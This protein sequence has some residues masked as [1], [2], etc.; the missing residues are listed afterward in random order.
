VAVGIDVSLYFQ[1]PIFDVPSG[2]ALAKSLEA[3]SSKRLPPVCLE[4]LSEMN[5]SAEALS[6]VWRANAVAAVDK[7]P[8]DAALDAI[9]GGI[10]ARLSAY[11]ALPAANYPVAAKAL[12][13]KE[14]LFPDGL[15]FLKLAYVEEWAESDK[16]MRQIEDL[17]LEGALEKFVGRDFVE[18]LGKAHEVYGAVLG[19]T[20][21][22]RP[23]A[24]LPDL[25]EKLREVRQTMAAYVL[26]LVAHVGKDADMVALI[27]HAL[28]PIDEFRANAGARRAR[29][30]A[31]AD[32]GREPA[33]PRGEAVPDAPV[34]PVPPAADD[35][36][37]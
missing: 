16:R 6:V 1:V 24:E 23:R 27:R 10:H 26:S 14:R 15:G 5:E 28:R 19:I 32:E 3:T 34:A 11:S 37:T 35:D 33:A 20:R 4:R 25:Q 30:N 22:G 29:G 18:Q 9:W 17:K 31:G 21:D 13:I 8:A 36:P 12:E 2:L 7:R